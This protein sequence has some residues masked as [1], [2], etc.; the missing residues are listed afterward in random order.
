MLPPRKRSRDPSSAYYHKVSVEVSTEIDIED[1]IERWTKR[2][3]KD[4]YEA[5]TESD[6]DSNILP[7]IK[8]DIAVDVAAAIEDDT[9]TDV[10]VVVEADVELVEAGMSTIREWLDEIEEVVQGIYEHSLAILA[11]RL[12]DIKEEQRA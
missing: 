10:V 1:S 8:A 3:I 9:T 4:N 5:D 7:D 11:H 6:I 12:D 2:D